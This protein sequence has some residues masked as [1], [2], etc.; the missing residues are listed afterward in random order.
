M[1]TS[2]LKVVIP[3]LF[4]AATAD[5]ASTVYAIQH[6][7]VEVDPL[8]VWVFGTNKPTAFV[9]Y[10]R[11][12]AIIAAEAVAATFAGRV[13]GYIIGSA[14]LVQAAVHAYE[15]IKAFRRPS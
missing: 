14:L 1:L 9:I 5:G 11:G 6:G 7:C 12:A 2:L 4:A 3:V 8:M 15:A 10:T 13:G